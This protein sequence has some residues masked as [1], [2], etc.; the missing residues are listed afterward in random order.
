MKHSSFHHLAW[1]ASTQMISAL[2]VGVGGGLLLHN[3]LKFGIWVLI[4][5]FILGMAAGFLNVYRL[6]K[7]MKS[8][9]S[10]DFQK[11]KE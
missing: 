4:L 5:G 11:K 10:L 9:P 6:T 3:Y 2:M 1:Q 8:D 7:K